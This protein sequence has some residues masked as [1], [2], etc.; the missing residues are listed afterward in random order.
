M[1]S[2]SEQRLSVRRQIGVQGGPA[3]CL[4]EEHDGGRVRSYT[5]LLIQPFGSRCI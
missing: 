1:R 3:L 5:R 4:G 2:G